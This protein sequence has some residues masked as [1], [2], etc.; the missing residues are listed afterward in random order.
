MVKHRQEQT[1]RGFCINA[2]QIPVHIGPCQVAW[3]EFDPVWWAQ[4]VI[5]TRGEIA[6]EA[7][8]WVWV[9]SYGFAT[10]CSPLALL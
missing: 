10:L 6:K 8:Q 9:I 3:S 4:M 1:K 7:R 5:A 2:C